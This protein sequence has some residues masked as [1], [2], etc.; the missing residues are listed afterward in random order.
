[1]LPLHTSDQT[2][3]SLD[4]GKRNHRHCCQLGHGHHPGAGSTADLSRRC[5]PAAQALGG[6]G[7]GNLPPVV[8]AVRAAVRAAQAIQKLEEYFDLMADE[9]E[10]VGR[11]P[12]EAG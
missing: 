2:M 6:A 11:H 3:T 4:I 8:R 5:A 7:Y 12:I 9:D 1:M 10:G